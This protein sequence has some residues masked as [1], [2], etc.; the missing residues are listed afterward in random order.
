[1]EEVHGLRVVAQ[2][3]VH[4]TGVVAGFGK[5]A[6]A[7][8]VFVIVYDGEGRAV[9][10][11]RVVRKAGGLEPQQLE[12]HPVGLL[13]GGHGWGE[14]VEPRGGGLGCGLGEAVE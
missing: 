6:C 7:G 8:R 4:L 14:R 5:A 10:L 9:R 2:G 3:E 12:V 13:G 1:M 11:R